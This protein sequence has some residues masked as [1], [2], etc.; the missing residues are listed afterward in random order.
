[1]YDTKNKELRWNATYYDYAAT[2]P[3]E[4]TNYKMSHF[5]SNG[6]GLVVTVDSDSGD[7]LWIQNYASPVVALYIWQ[8]E[9]LRKVLHTNVGVET[10][11][12]LTFMS[13]RSAVSQSGSIP[14]PKKLRPKSKLM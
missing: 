13:G 11:R 1:M 8:R 9:G 12:Y 5:V 7:V 2:L 3:D 14:F 10:L 4:G 6:D